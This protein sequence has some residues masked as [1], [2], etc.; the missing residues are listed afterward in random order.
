MQSVVDWVQGRSGRKASINASLSTANVG[1]D[2]NC[3]R[4]LQVGLKGDTGEEGSGW[5]GNWQ[6]L[7]AKTHSGGGLRGGGSDEFIVRLG[8]ALGY[9]A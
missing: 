1:G 6:L 2:T 7:L 3:W 4:P 5:G 8:R 9:P